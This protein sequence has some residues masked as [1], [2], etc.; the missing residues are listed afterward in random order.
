[1]TRRT[2]LFAPGLLCAQVP[3]PSLSILWTTARSVP[4]EF[5]RESVVFTRAYAGCP[6][7]G[8]A[9]GVVERGRFPHAWRSN[10]PVA[11]DYF[12]APPAGGATVTILTAGSGDG[13][14]SPFDRSLRVPLAI[15]WPG[16]LAPRVITDVLASHADVFPT[17]LGL[18]GLAPPAGLQGRD[19]SARLLTGRGPLPDSVYAQGRI[20]TTAEWRMV[21]RGFDKI[22]WNLRDEVTGLYNLADDPGEMINLAGRRQHRLTQDSMWALAQQWMRRLGDGMDPSGLRLQR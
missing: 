12:P 2:L 15:R 19:L 11:S 8:R 9:R 5:A 20:G 3:R 13:E 21:L 1:M 10:D 6:D 4:A 16:R 22:I 7:A 14:D 17:L 18:A